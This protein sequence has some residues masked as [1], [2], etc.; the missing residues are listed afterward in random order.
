MAPQARGSCPPAGPSQLSLAGEEHRTPY[1]GPGDK[2]PAP[3]SA[4]AVRRHLLGLLETLPRGSRHAGSE[5][6]CRGG[7]RARQAPATVRPT[8]CPTPPGAVPRWHGAESQVSPRSRISHGWVTAPRLPPR[9]AAPAAAEVPQSIPQ[10]LLF[11]V[12]AS[13]REGAALG[14]Q[15]L[16]RQRP[17]VPLHR[18][19]RR[20]K[21]HPPP[22]RRL[23]G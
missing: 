1:P 10:R 16:Q 17:R 18:G 5:S 14:R 2:D 20:E 12:T 6:R 21:I 23:W 4:V 22:A 8:R 9:S 3:R 19:S 11:H 15:L 7:T 13:G